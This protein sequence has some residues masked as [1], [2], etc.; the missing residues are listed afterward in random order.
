MTGLLRPLRH[1]PGRIPLAALI[2]FLAIFAIVN[3]GLL[4]PFQLATSVNVMAPLI[5][6]A[7]AQFLVIM[8]GGIDLSIAALM[9]LTNVVFVQLSMVVG[10]YPALVLTLLLG[11][12]CGAVNGALVGYVRLPSV[13]VTLATSFIFMAG[14]VLVQDRPGGMVPFSFM[15]AATGLWFGLF[16]AALLWILFVGFGM[17]WFLRSTVMGKVI[18]AAGRSELGVISAGH[19]PA[20]AKL[21]AFTIAGIVAAAAAILLAGAAASGDP[22]AGTPYL[23]NS[24][25]A[26]AI[27]GGIFSGRKGTVLGVIC[28]A[29]ILALLDSLLFFANIA[30]S[31]KYVIGGLIIVLTVMLSSIAE[32]L[33]ERRQI[34]G[35]TA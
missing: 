35:S 28:G 7:L 9:N 30:G 22:R 5:F 24:I 34:E 2:V 27:G 10:P 21:A 14:A 18:F 33:K 16:P 19:D 3:P 8:T 4:D 15:E 20:L 1:H 11:G 23:L 13:V 32:W 25:A 31:W 26:V 17:A 12:A 29:S 6:A